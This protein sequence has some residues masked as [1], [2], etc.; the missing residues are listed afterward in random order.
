MR[1]LDIPRIDLESLSYQYLSLF[2]QFL[3]RSLISVMLHIDPISLSGLFGFHQLHFPV[4][5]GAVKPFQ[6]CK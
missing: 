3:L 6:Q 4:L 1:N 2:I 5:S